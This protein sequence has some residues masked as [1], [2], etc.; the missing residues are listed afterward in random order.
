MLATLFDHIPAAPSAPHIRRR[1]APSGDHVRYSRYPGKGRKEQLRWW[2]K[3]HG[4]VNLGL[5][6]REMLTTVRRKLLPLTSKYPLTPLGLWQ[7]LQVVLKE[8]RAQGVVVPEVWPK[9]VER[10]DGGFMAH[11]TQR[12]ERIECPGP[13]PT[14]EE[15]HAAILAELARVFPPRKVKRYRTLFDFTKLPTVEQ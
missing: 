14:P 5:Y 3:A 6:D 8:L 11:V 2:L 10:V 7:A 13:Y 9:Y 4:S 15:A 1:R 12:G